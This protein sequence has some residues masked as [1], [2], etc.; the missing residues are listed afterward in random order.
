MKMAGLHLYYKT[1]INLA[2]HKSWDLP[3]PAVLAMRGQS[4]MALPDNMYSGVG[5]LEYWSNAGIEIPNHKSQ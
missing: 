2:P 3:P 1:P 4:S 5:V